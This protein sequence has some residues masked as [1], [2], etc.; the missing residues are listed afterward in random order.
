M[1][2][3]T[4]NL[5]PESDGASMKTVRQQRF[6]WLVA[7]ASL[8]A[9][10]TGL[11]FAHSCGWLEPP[12][13][14]VNRL[15]HRG[16]EGTGTN[17]PEMDM[18]SMQREPAGKSANVPGHGEVTIPREVQQR[19]GVTVGK[20][21]SADFLID[22]ES[23]LRVAGGMAGM[24]GM[25]KG[26]GISSADVGRVFEPFFPSAD[27]RRRAVGGLGLGLAV[28]A[29]IIRSFGGRIEVWSESSSGSRFTVRL[30]HRQGPIVNDIDQPQPSTAISI[31][32]FGSV[33]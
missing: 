12:Y 16:H 30:P 5:L 28:A 19:I 15:T 4:A 10:G 1:S 33:N 21:T 23:R 18:G 17:M 24:P 26:H 13:A 32:E 8:V 7:L 2:S 9:I 27:T 6:L 22:S 20:V 25:D 3:R 14:W 29:R 31:A 11:W